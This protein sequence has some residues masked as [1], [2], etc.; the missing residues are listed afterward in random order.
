MATVIDQAIRP[1]SIE[2]AAAGHTDIGK[3]LHNEDAINLRPDL[4][5]YV[6]AD[7]AG[8][9]KAG[10]V[11]SAIAVT[12]IANFFESTARAMAGK[13]DIDDFGLSIGARRVAA[14]IQ[15]ASRDVVEIAKS[16]HKYRGMGST[17]V[18]ASFVPE[19]HTLH[20][21]HVGDSRCY[22]LRGAYLE[23]LTHDHSLLN[24]VL[25]EHPTIDD[26]MLHRLP[27]HVVTRALGMEE[28]V[29]V[30][31]R[32]FVVAPGDRYLLCS[33]G[34]T[35]SLDDETIA[36]LLSESKPKEDLVRGLVEAAKFAGGDDNIA[37]VVLECR[38]PDGPG[39]LPR[40]LDRRPS[41]PDPSE[42]RPPAASSPEII[43]LDEQIAVVPEES[44]T[45]SLM[46][47]FAGLA[48]L[49]PPR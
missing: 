1:R 37:A 16:S 47:A 33:D 3:R 19:T 21:A 6:L 49:K 31:V 32:S 8:G 38:L 35:E 36:L 24:D 45:Q 26:A 22:R 29:R 13:P 34:L 46:D 2:I 28:A 17:V 30:S 9:H 44:A 40:A 41:R 39:K 12:S 23:Q 42:V 48:K 11:A 14:A 10:N 43:V 25:E 20:V 7:G 15:R 5:L 4:H 27:R 18:A